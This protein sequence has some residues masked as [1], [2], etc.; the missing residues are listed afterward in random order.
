MQLIVW[1]HKKYDTTNFEP[2]LR[3]ELVIP[4][5]SGKRVITV[6]SQVR[7][8]YLVILTLT[9]CF[10]LKFFAPIMQFCLFRV[11]LTKQPLGLCR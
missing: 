7:L 1:T 11:A 9:K 8:L 4:G 6:I 2:R 3:H 10:I 5:S